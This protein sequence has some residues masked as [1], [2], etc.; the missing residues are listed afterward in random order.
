MAHYL[1]IATDGDGT[2]TTRGS[3]SRAVVRALQKLRDAGRKALLVT[4]KKLKSAEEF[5]HVH[6]FDRVIAENGAIL[7]DPS[8][9]ASRR[10]CEPRPEDLLPMLEAR[11]GC[12]SGGQVA[13]M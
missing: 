3:M 9:G 4:G 13:I 6:L 11:V 8:S 10:L 5:P 7:F 2:L 12:V 1:A